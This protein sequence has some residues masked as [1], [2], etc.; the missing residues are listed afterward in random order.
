MKDTVF[1]GHA[2]PED[3]DFAIWL[4][5]KLELSGYKVWCDLE[6]L[7]GG[8]RDFWE[9]IQ[10][11]LEKET[12]K[13]LLVFSKNA[14]KKD[15]VKD[16]Y[17]FARNIAKKQN[18]NDFVIPLRIDNVSYEDRIGINR[19]NIINFN[20]S[21]MP[22]LWKLLKKLEKD[23]T[24]KNRKAGDD[25]PDKILNMYHIDSK[26]IKKEKERYY[27]NWWRIPKLPPKIFLFQYQDEDFAK[28][29][30]EEGADYP[31]IRHGNYL[32]SFEEKIKKYSENHG[33]I[34]IR[35]TERKA[36][37]VKGILDRVDFY[38]FPTLNDS[39]NFLKRLLKKSFKNLMYEKGLGKKDLSKDQCFYHRA[40]MREGKIINY[41]QSIKYHNRKKSKALVGKY[42]DSFWHYAVS[43]QV[44]LHPFVC[45]S[46]KSHILF[47]YDGL[48]IWD[49]DSKLHSARRAKGK[50]WFNEEWR[51]QLNAFIRALAWKERQIAIRLNKNFVTYMP[52]LTK[53]FF[54]DIGYIEPGTKHRLSILHESDD[55]LNDS[56]DDSE[57]SD[58]D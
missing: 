38:E 13:Y 2:T 21:W 27:S 46:L 56:E 17:E 12:H 16:E 43:A 34:R 1:I 28:M 14:F 35:Y 31:V 18:L 29:I 36:I 49:N 40:R 3:N 25:Y 8:E 24:P 44:R 15:G 41:R 57:T 5:S 30:L 26:V 52:F 6:D 54:S 48:N 53:Q 50:R 55:E 37:D 11:I 47:S 51:D 10:R 33:N 58:Q 22:G 4:Y 20:D 39:E 19:Y 23:K 45:F 7:I 32:I 42:Y 9:V